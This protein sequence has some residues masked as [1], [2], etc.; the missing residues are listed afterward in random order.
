MRPATTQN[1]PKV[2]HHAPHVK[3]TGRERRRA[4]ERRRDGKQCDHAKT[5]LTEPCN[6]GGTV[7]RTSPPPPPP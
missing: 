2:G 4:M 7:E 6:G 5:T 3:A 1:Y